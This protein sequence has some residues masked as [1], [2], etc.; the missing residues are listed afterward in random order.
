[1]SSIGTPDSA[2]TRRGVR[3]PWQLQAFTAIVLVGLGIWQVGGPTASGATPEI[4]SSEAASVVPTVPLETHEG[5]GAIKPALLE[6]PA[7][8]V[9]APTPGLNLSGPRPEVP[10]DFDQAGWYEQ[11]RLPGDIGPAVFAGHIDSFTGPAVFA[12]LGELQRDDEVTVT[13][14]DGNIRRFEV[15]RSGQYPKGDLPDDVFESDDAIPE[16]RLIT[17]GGT[18]D[19]SSGHYLENFV[20]FAREST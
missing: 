9:S 20:I 11:T 8:D 5:T 7:I 19:K 10:H 2:P 13:D 17:C 12:R 6:I 14:A 4:A 16:L 18:F 1:M 15:T 3:V